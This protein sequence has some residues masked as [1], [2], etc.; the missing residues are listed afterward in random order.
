[1]IKRWEDIG[2]RK[3]LVDIDNLPTSSAFEPWERELLHAIPQ[4]LLNYARYRDWF[5]RETMND[6]AALTGQQFDT[7]EQADAAITE[8]IAEENT[9]LDAQLVQLGHRRTLRLSMIIAGT[10]PDD[11]NPL[12]HRLDPIFD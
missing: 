11:N 1:M 9:A 12:F 2:F 7:I 3:M 10:N 5:E 4:F 6:I 8:L